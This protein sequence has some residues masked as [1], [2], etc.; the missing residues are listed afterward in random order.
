MGLGTLKDFSVV[1]WNVQSTFRRPPAFRWDSLW[2]IVAGYTSFTRVAPALEKMHADIIVLQEIHDAKEKFE[3]YKF[4]L[5]YNV[6][7]PALNSKVYH[8]Q[9]GFNS[10]V[11]LTKFPI[12]ASKEIS[13]PTTKKY[14]EHCSRVDML[15]DDQILRVYAC[16]F[17]IFGVGVATRATLLDY[18]LSDAA[19][20]AGPIIICGDLNTTIPRSGWRRAVVR[21]WHQ[22][23][24]NELMVDGKI[25]REDERYVIKN[26]LNRHAFTDVLDINAPTWSPIKSIH[27]E[28]FGLKLDWCM[29]KKLQVQSVHLGQ[30]ISDHR[31]ILVR[32]ALPE[33]Q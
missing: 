2:H 25:A 5:E 32:C 14:A 4:F 19:T 18:V 16:H 27:G 26:I 15:V 29:I 13:F 31:S 33:V 9:K 20:H 10:N 12:V 21:L 11:V 22:V 3:R 17:P 7:I 1:S 30:Y 6:Y 8:G 24:R 28:L 23:F